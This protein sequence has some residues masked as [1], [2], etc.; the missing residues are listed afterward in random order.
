MNEFTYTEI[1]IALILSIFLTLWIRDL[2]NDE[3]ELVDVVV[4]GVEHVWWE[5][6]KYND[7]EATVDTLSDEA[8]RRLNTRGAIDY[9]IP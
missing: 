9:V 4:Q 8:V 1:L 2:F 3:V 7:V 6:S 5:E